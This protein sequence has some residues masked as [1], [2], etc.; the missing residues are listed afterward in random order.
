MHVSSSAARVVS[1]YGEE[2]SGT[3]WPST[4]A[5]VQ[6]DSVLVLMHQRGA[7]Q[8]L[9]AADAAAAAA[10]CRAAVAVLPT[11][12]WTPAPRAS[13]DGWLGLLVLEGLL[14]RSVEINGLRAQELLGPGD[15]LRPWDGA[16]AD[17]AS[18][19]TST[20][21]TVLDRTTVAVLDR[22]FCATAARWPI[23][24]T[25]LLEFAMK[26]FDTR[27]VLLAAI[28]ARRADTRL[29]L[30]FWH[31]AD[32]WGRVSHDGVIVPLTLTHDRLS[33]L[34]CLRRPTVTAALSRLRL[35]QQLRRRP[36]GTW[37]LAPESL[38]TLST[39]PGLVPMS[40]VLD[41]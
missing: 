31:F 22:R 16:A 20:S 30:L 26:R 21:W 24:L 35:A 37:L 19:A 3:F 34:V 36:D 10:S 6:P 4:A 38:A 18:V 40:A 9:G 11:G 2:P 29:L 15:I 5:R 33:E 39:E 41:R 27:A 32:R 14:T 17:A 8:G 23:V 7:L 12:G 28:R 13:V 25:N 1:L